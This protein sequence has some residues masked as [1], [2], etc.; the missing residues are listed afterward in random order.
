MTPTLPT[1]TTLAWGLTEAL[2][3]PTSRQKLKHHL[4]L[5]DE[6]NIQALQPHTLVTMTKYTEAKYPASNTHIKTHIKID[7]KYP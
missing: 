4:N 2:C 6:A 7:A 5:L 3:V 1:T